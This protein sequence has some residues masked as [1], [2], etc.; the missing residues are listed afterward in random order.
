MTFFA[1]HC[2]LV[3]NRTPADV[4]TFFCSSLIFNGKL[5][6]VVLPMLCIA[7]VCKRLLTWHD[8]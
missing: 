3:E 6:G 4:M 5:M 1:L 7:F 2:F 8:I